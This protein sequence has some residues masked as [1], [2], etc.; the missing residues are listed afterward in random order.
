MSAGAR[1][2]LYE[3]TTV[4]PLLSTA[5][6]RQ[7]GLP[8]PAASSPGCPLL[9]GE[10]A[11]VGP[12]CVVPCFQPKPALFSAPDLLECRLSQLEL[13]VGCAAVIRKPLDK[14][15]IHMLREVSAVLHS[16]CSLAEQSPV[17]PSQRPATWPACWLTACAALCGYA[18]LTS[19]PAG[20]SGHGSA[21]GEQP[22]AE[23]GGQAQQ[24]APGGQLCQSGKVAPARPCACMG[25][26]PA[27]GCSLHH[28]L[29]T[30]GWWCSL[31]RLTCA[32]CTCLPGLPARAWQAQQAPESAASGWPKVHTKGGDAS[33]CSRSWP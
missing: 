16:A 33:A 7:C 13:T 20:Q 9:A 10:P 2:L 15:F 23:G 17:G 5:I 25:C 24:A 30:T 27:S 28:R 32:S 1:S 8:P 29:P 3:A 14:C 18:A 19:G 11:C 26:P 6:L 31:A 21:P 12:A 22:Q 4:I